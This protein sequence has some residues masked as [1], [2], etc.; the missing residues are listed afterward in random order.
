MNENGAPISQVLSRKQT[1][2]PFSL[3]DGN[4]NAETHRAIQNKEVSHTKMFELE[5]SSQNIISRNSQAYPNQLTFSIESCV[6][7]LFKY[8][9]LLI[10]NNSHEK[11]SF[12][13]KFIFWI[14]MRKC[15]L[16]GTHSH[17]YF[18]IFFPFDLYCNLSFV[19]VKVFKKLP[20]KLESFNSQRWQFN[21]NSF[22]KI[23]KWEC[24]LTTHQCHWHT[25]G[26]S[27]LEWHYTQ[28]LFICS[29]KIIWSNE[30]FIISKT[31]S[32]EVINC[33]SFSKH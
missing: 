3:H 21:V 8:L 22:D 32:R 18:T 16:V 33:M 12:W 10:K 27:K 17:S 13:S 20:F 24:S 23:V 25:V 26:S 5:L 15:L 30:Q 6:K 14:M 4:W 11:H 9:L 7:N 19:S 1:K 28:L 29:D 2:W 31:L